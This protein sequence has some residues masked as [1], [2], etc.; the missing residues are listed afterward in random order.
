MKIAVL[1]FSALGD[2]A[3]TLPVVWS[4]AK[5]NPNTDFIIV[6][7]PWLCSIY[8]DLLPNISTYPC[9]PHGSHAGIFGMWRL[10]KEL[11]ALHIDTVA[12]LHDVLRTKMLRTFLYVL[13]CKY[14]FINKGRKQRSKLI[15][16]TKYAVPASQISNSDSSLIELP[17]QH[18]KYADVFKSLGLNFS[19]T[20]QS[21]DLPL[22]P[23]LFQKQSNQRWIGVAPTAAHLSKVLPIDKL[24][25]ILTE[26]LQSKSTKVFFFGRETDVVS[27]S[28]SLATQFPD[29]VYHSSQFANGLRDELRLMQQLDVMVSMDSGNMHLASLVGIRVVS[30]WGV[31]HPAMG[32]LGYGQSIDD[33]VACRY[34]CRP[35]SVY[36][37]HTRCTDTF[38]CMSNISNEELLQKIL[39]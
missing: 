25:S 2:V 9:E 24:T 18:S 11:K 6:T 27:L 7:Q 35:C 12:D 20:F 3:M 23:Q 31:T 29:K 19:L 17:S 1:R 26:V 13:G 22:L 4:V 8:K 10:A 32:F 37:Q 34:A 39:S 16:Q 5:D 36:G 15:Q 21:L 33:C 28:Q 30:V 14:K 38:P